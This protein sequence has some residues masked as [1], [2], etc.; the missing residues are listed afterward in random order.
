M[1]SS[2]FV[3]KESSGSQSVKDLKVKL[4]KKVL[5]NNWR[6]EAINT[7]AFSSWTQ[8]KITNP[9][10]DPFIEDKKSLV[11]KNRLH[12]KEIENELIYPD[13]TQRAKTKSLTRKK[14]PALQ[15]KYQPSARAYEAS[16]FMNDYQPR[17]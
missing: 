12:H 17:S 2:S 9:S 7:K 5:E 11:L 16:L 3:A 10:A 1:G 13:G 15:L 14:G 8:T 6:K 4:Q